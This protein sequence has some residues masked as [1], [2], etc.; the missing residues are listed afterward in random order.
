MASTVPAP[1]TTA[2]PHLALL[3][4]VP[5]E[6]DDA[7]ERESHAMAAF[8]DIADRS[9][10]AG[11]A[12]VT[13]GLSPAALMQAELDWMTHLAFSPGKR[14]QLVDK[15]VRKAVRF[16]NYAAR[17]A[18]EGGTAEAC[19]APLS[20]DRRFASEHWQAFPFNWIHQGFCCSSN[21]GTTR[22]LAFAASRTST[23]RWCP[24]WP[25]NCSTWSRPRISWRQTP[26]CSTAP[27][28]P[29]GPISCR[30]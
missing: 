4:A 18:T 16:A 22:R 26:T 9:L 8:A 27:S 10:H 29:A 30:A 21:G 11:L 12:A 14:M 24:S 6:C 15:A 5:A 19:I 13:L 20:Q 25:A 1:A 2:L 7:A 17:C 23:R 3:P 28:A